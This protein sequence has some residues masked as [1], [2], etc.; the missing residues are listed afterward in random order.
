M[1]VGLVGLRW[2]RQHRPLVVSSRDSSGVLVVVVL[3]A[4][5]EDD[6]SFEQSV[7]LFAGQQ[8]VSEPASDDSR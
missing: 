3:L 4:V 8:L 6:L 7:E 1:R 5:A 2:V